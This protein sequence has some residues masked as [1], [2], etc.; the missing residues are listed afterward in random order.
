[1]GKTSSLYEYGD[2]TGLCAS[3]VK[4]LEAAKPITS[5]TPTNAIECLMLTIRR[6]KR[7]DAHGETTVR[8]VDF[9]LVAQIAVRVELPGAADDFFDRHRGFGPLGFADRRELTLDDERDGLGRHGWHPHLGVLTHGDH[10]LDFV[11]ALR[12][13]FQEVREGRRKI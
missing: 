10:L 13:L 5:A 3:T 7:C 4:R 1:M 12:Q 6:P 2:V 11:R 9:F 8:G